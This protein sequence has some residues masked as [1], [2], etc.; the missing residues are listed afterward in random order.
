MY[1]DPR[2]W[3]LDTQVICDILQ[4]GGIV[5]GPYKDHNHS[6]ELIFCNPDLIWRNDFERPRIGQGGFRVAFQAVYKVRVET[7]DHFFRL[8]V[9]HSQE[10]T[11]SAYPY[12]QYGK[13]TAATYKFAENV[14]RERLAEIQGGAVRSM[15]SV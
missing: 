5:G 10:L 2:N 11:G 13:P 14:L 7:I 15:P 8:F 3:A 9:M 12:T 4:S 6:V 1:H